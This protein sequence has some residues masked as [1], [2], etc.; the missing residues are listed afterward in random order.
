MKDINLHKRLLKLLFDHKEEHVGSSFTCLDIIDDIFDK[1]DKDDIF[2]LSNGH[3]AYALYS[4]LEKYYDH[5]DA[6]DL[7]TR[8]G[9]HPNRDEKNHI[10]C[11]TGSLG[12]GISIAVG[13]AL[14]NKNRKVYVTIT[15]GECAEGSV[16]E[17]LRFIADK[18]VDN[19]EVHC[20]ANGWACYDTI[21]VNTLEKRL[22]SF[23]PSIHIHKTNFNMLSFLKG[24][25][26]HYMIMTEEEYKQGLKEIK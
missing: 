23:L 7:A 24:L 4:V 9:G 16:W 25:N 3:A 6:D 22:K 10:Y 26:A 11:S 2:V 1:K 5:I 14:A 15:D 19:I 21:D 17:A 12:S 8:H 18:N 13:L 20:N